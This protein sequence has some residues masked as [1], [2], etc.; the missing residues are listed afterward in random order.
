MATAKHIFQRLL[1]NAANQK[2][3]DFLDELQK[4]AKDAFGV[5]AQAIIGQFIYANMPSHL[6]KSLNQ[7]HLENGSYKQIMSHLRRELEL[8]GLEAPHKMQRNTVTQ[9]ANKLHN[10]TLKIPNHFATITNSQVTIDISAVN[11][12]ESKTNSEITRIVPEIFNNNNASAQTNSN[13][14]IKFHTLPMR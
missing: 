12:N 5:A 1:F 6:K 9:Q 2:L 3:I 14:T 11:S 7:A 13:P 10:K 4:L 8:N